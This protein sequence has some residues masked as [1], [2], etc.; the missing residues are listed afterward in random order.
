M[1][2]LDAKLKHLELIQHVVNRFAQNSFLI[3]AWTV[4]LTSALFT[5]SIKEH[6][7]NYLYVTFLPVLIFS[8]LDSYY[9]A[10]E[11][12]YRLFYERSVKAKTTNL[13]LDCNVKED[14]HEKW[15]WSFL[16]TTNVL[17]YGGMVSI[18]VFALVWWR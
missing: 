6:N 1:S 16:S 8:L 3:K 14:E 13:S 9:L 7:N 11:R 5:F 10:L 15:F 17:F 2:D 4:T 18:V 12:R